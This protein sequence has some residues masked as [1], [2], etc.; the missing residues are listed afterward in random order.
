MNISIKKLFHREPG[1][2]EKLVRFILKYKDKPIPLRESV[3]KPEILIPCYNHGRYLPGLLNN[4]YEIKLPITIINDNSDDNTED[5]IMNLKQRYSFKYIK[6]SENLLQS[7]SLNRAIAASDNN[8]FIVVNA[9]D[10]LVPKWV[11]YAVKSFEFSDIRMLGGGNVSFKNVLFE[12]ELIV[13]EMIKSIEYLPSSPFRVY[14]P[15]DAIN[16]STDNAID[17]TMSGCTFLK[18]A[19]EFVDGFYSRNARVSIHD[20]RDFQMRVCSFF[21]IGISS[22]ICAFW[23]SDS[24]HGMG[25]L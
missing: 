10:L 5:V 9:D 12:T 18:S 19:W 23:R 1:L 16:F 17:M 20:D 22:E 14:G 2:N 15:E 21:N 11:D 13:S 4:V 6:N 7:G 3:F 8:M 25:V 24:S